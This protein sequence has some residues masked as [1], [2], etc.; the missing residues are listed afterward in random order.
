M[1]EEIKI[2]VLLSASV[3]RFGVSR[4]QDFCLGPRNR[5]LPASQLIKTRINTASKGKTID[6]KITNVFL[7]N[8]FITV[9]IL[10]FCNLFCKVSK[11]L[12]NTKN[13]KKKGQ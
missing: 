5:C 6:N 13:G 10:Y 8:T 4:M 3:K 9:F 2:L 11:V 1:P 12:I 7:I